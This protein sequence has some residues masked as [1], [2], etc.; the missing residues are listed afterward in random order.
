MRKG[1]NQPVWSD[2]A[3]LCTLGNFSKPVDIIILPKL[4]TFLGNFCIGVKIFHFSIEI[5]FGATFIDIW[6]LF[7]GHAAYLYL[8]SHKKFGHNL[9]YNTLKIA[10]DFDN[11][12]KWRNFVK[13]GHTGLFSVQSIFIFGNKNFF[14]RKITTF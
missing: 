8:T 11:L 5:I 3:I 6:R 9:G 13:S 1:V 14:C 10:Q 2:W 7:T 12:P 4:P